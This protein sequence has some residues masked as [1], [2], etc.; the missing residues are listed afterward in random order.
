MP[1]VKVKPW[2]EKDLKEFREELAKQPKV[3]P[4]QKPAG[5]W[6]KPNLR[7]WGRI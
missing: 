1:L 5:F 7:Y 4:E 3:Y 6:D 2:T